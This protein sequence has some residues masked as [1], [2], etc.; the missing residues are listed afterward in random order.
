MKKKYCLLLVCSAILFTTNLKAQGAIAGLASE[1]GLTLNQPQCGS[2]ELMKNR[3]QSQEGFMEL[4]DQFM[5]NVVRIVQTQKQNREA[6]D[7]YIIPVVFH[8]VYNETEENLADSVIYNQLEILN[9]CFRRENEDKSETREEFNEI[10][11]DTRIEFQL[12]ETDPSGGLTTGI[13]RTNTD[14]EYF[15]GVLPYGPSEGAEIADWINDSLYYNFFRLT[16]TSLGGKDAWDT[17][18][19]LNVWIGD[20]RIFEPEF[21]DFEE[22]VF[23]ALATPPLDHE[24]WP[25]EVIDLLTEFEQG[26]LIHYVNVGANNPNSFPA[27]YGTFNDK[28]TT[29]KILV[30]EVGHYL[31]LRHIWGDGD[32]DMDDFIADTPKSNNSSNWNCDHGA[33][34]CLD[35]IGGI[36]LSN[37]VEN[38]MDYSRGSCQNSFTIG[39]A[40]VMRTVL[41]EHRPFLY[42][43]LSMVSI[44]ESSQISRVKI[45]PNPTTGAFNVDF[46]QA[47]NTATIHIYNGIGKIVFTETIE[48]ASSTFISLQLS[49]GIYYI[50]LTSERMSSEPNKFVIN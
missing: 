24:N 23:F 16:E 2:F 47:F 39:Q 12:A 31:G 49:P 7:L 22:L 9:K 35:D 41:E 26:V 11:G 25:A 4:S 29:G 32:C 45:Y 13:T 18:Q 20:L 21:D 1:E 42:E 17:D 5:E 48:N 34:S 10:V 43:T 44:E 8:V 6:S 27:P 46:G 3:A 36:D 37:M 40:D 33:N 14:V 15:G 28:T 38:Y 30:H 50:Y 19:Y